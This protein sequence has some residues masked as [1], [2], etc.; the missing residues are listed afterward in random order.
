[1]SLTRNDQRAVV[2]HYS[3]GRDSVQLPVTTLP[4]PDQTTCGPTCLHAI[5]RDWGDDESL[6][7]VIG[8]LPTL[9]HGGTLAVFLGC[10]ALR[11]HYRVTILTYNLLF[12]PTWF[13]SRS[14]DLA[15]KLRRQQA[16]KTDYQLQY[17]TEGYLEFLDHG[18]RL[19]FSNLAQHLI[20]GILRRK[21][22]ILTGLS[23]TYLYCSAREYRPA[24][25]RDDVRGLPARHF[26]V[27]AAYDS[28]RRQVMVVDP[29]QPTRTVPLTSTG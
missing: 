3:I 20:P 23:S 25:V 6:P 26:V 8:R 2:S 29:Y 9:E 10:D 21:L 1:M 12:D 4:Q 22:P 7:T 11:K 24:D 28:S 13:A 14:I 5:Y 27:I 18:G 17:A 16:T 15:E 19:R